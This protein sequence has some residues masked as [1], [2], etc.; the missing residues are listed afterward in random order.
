MKT[1]FFSTLA[2][3]VFF[4]ASAFAEVKD[5]TPAE[6]NEAVARLLERRITFP[7]EAKDDNVIGSVAIELKLTEE[8]TLE[9]RQLATESTVLSEHLER[10]IKRLEKNLK[11]VMQP[12][13]VQRYR[14]T[15]KTI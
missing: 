11:Q 3:F 2:V 12:G 9:F 10:Q 1:R 15:F 7:V 14:L 4:F 5:V 13:E 8:N 6:N